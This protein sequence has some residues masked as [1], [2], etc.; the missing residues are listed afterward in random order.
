MG[1]FA[2]PPMA[3]PVRQQSQCASKSTPRAGT[4]PRC[5]PS[6]P[7]ICLDD[8]GS[9]RQKVTRSPDSAP[10]LP[11][12]HLSDISLHFR[13][14]EFGYPG[15]V[16]WPLVA[17]A[18]PRFENCNRQWCGFSTHEWAFP[19]S[20]YDYRKVKTFPVFHCLGCCK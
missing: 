3:A 15:T 10:P 6:L 9:P 1:G 8:P 20:R 16:A 17:I 12:Y 7:N 14:G 11:A 5:S 4:T 19:K 18:G 2:C 13:H